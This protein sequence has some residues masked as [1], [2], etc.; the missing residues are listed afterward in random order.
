MI[1][2]APRIKRKSSSLFSAEKI[3]Q[4]A[5]EGEMPEIFTNIYRDD[6]NIAVWKRQVSSELALASSD[7]LILLRLLLVSTNSCDEKGSRHNVSSTIIDSPL[8]ALRK[9]TGSRQR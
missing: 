4:S 8:I 6:C 3:I 7:I 1:S 2:V 9:S 5:S